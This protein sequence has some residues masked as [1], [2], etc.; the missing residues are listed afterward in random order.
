MHAAAKHSD[1]VRMLIADRTFS[2]L[3]TTAAAL[4]GGWTKFFLWVSVVHAHNLN[5]YFKIPNDIHKVLIYEAKDLTI[6]D[7]V[8]LRSAVSGKTISKPIFSRDFRKAFLESWYFLR[9][10]WSIILH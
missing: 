5:N 7:V 1:M 10:G 2:S 3:T 6:P 4:M 9:I 8:N